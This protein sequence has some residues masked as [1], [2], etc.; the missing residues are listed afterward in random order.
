MLLSTK[1]APDYEL[2][3]TVLRIRDDIFDAVQQWI[4]NLVGVSGPQQEQHLLD[5]IHMVMSIATS[6]GKEKDL[7][8]SGLLGRLAEALEMAPMSDD[9][10]SQ[11]RT[12]LMC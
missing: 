5:A 10:H 6:F 7:Q 3:N 11:R 4:P 2:T 12:A 1:A 9:R 8:G